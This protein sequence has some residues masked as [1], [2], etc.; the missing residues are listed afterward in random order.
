MRWIQ[1]EEWSP[2]D[3][4]ENSIVDLSHITAG[5]LLEIR[6]DIPSAEKPDTPKPAR[7]AVVQRHAGTLSQ[8]RV[9][10]QRHRAHDA[11]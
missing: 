4:I 9:L 8:A 2:G 10:A 5:K 7:T 6:P 3:I 11:A 1:A